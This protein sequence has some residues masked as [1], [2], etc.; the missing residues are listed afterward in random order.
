VRLDGFPAKI[1]IGFIMRH[2]HARISPVTARKAQLAVWAIIPS[3]NEG[4]A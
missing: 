1:H 2:S 3:G 4:A